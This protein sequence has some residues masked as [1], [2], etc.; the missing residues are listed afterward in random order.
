MLILVD[1]V[2]PWLWAG[3]AGVLAGQAASSDDPAH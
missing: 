1:G 2:E 3:Q